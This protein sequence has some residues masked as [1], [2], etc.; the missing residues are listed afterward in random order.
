[1]LKLVSSNAD[2]HVVEIFDRDETHIINTLIA[3]PNYRLEPTGK[4][5]FLFWETPP[6]T[7]RAMRA[8]FY[9]GDNFGQ[10]FRYPKNMRQIA[11]ASTTASV[12]APAPT[13][14]APAAPSPE[15]E[16][17]AQNQQ[18]AV[19]EQTVIIAQNTAPAA[20]APEVQPTPAEQPVPQELPKTASPFPLIGLAGLFSLSIFGWRKIKGTA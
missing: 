15:P 2:R 19:E 13:L 5:Q 14:S 6:G 17:V 10:E 7:A 8:W 9:P 12:A 16:P 18:S 4:S 1:V 3:I 11:S 20:P